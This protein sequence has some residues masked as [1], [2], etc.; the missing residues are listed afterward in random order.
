MDIA[1]WVVGSLASA[2]QGFGVGKKGDCPYNL[3]WDYYNF[4]CPRVI[5]KNKKD[6]E[7]ITETD[8]E[9]LPKYIDLLSHNNSYNI[10]DTQLT[11]DLMQKFESII[12]QTFEIPILEEQRK[13]QN[14]T[15]G[16]ISQTLD[17]YKFTSTPALSYYLWNIL[18]FTN[19]DPIPITIPKGKYEEA[20]DKGFI[21]ARCEMTILGDISIKNTPWLRKE[22]GIN[23]VDVSSEY[24]TADTGPFPT[25][26]P[27]SPSEQKIKKMKIFLRGM[28][29]RKITC[30]QLP[31]LLVVVKATPPQ[32][33]KFW[34]QIAP[35]P[36]KVA[37]KNKEWKT[38]AKLFNSY[39]PR[40]QYVTTSDIV[41][42]HNNFWNI[43]ILNSP[44]NIEFEKW[45]FPFRKYIFL[46]STL[47]EEY[48]KKGNMAGKNTIKLLM[49]GL[50]GFLAM[51][52]DFKRQILT[53][54]WNCVTSLLNNPSMNEH[55]IGE[56]GIKIDNSGEIFTCEYLDIRAKINSKYP[57]YMGWYT[58]SYGRMMVDHMYNMTDDDMGKTYFLTR[59]PTVFYT[60]TDS[61]KTTESKIDRFN[62]ITHPFQ[63][64]SFNIKKDEFDFLVKIEYPKNL[65]QEIMVLEKIFYCLADKNQELIA[66]KPKVATLKI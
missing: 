60:D 7:K 40:E 2:F 22:K 36:S 59:Y 46:C 52:T 43:E 31:P 48:V 4:K 39:I 55:E 3:L 35:V 65:C 28:Q 42:W 49:N 58:T 66:T 37:P 6:F 16:K 25:G 11:Y 62:D 17:I 20:I 63:I 41:V 32:Q 26:T 10:L 53:S 5:K 64:G 61:I 18:Y 30:T 29:N 47:K 57:R 24:P 8:F 54:D 44:F 9:Q 21:A 1:D 12:Y 51:N 45:S 13:F 15:V 33:T 23:E 14:H 19:P 56:V 27:Y 50:Y 34:K 38:C